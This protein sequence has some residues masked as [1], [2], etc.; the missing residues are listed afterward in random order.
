MYRLFIKQLISSYLVFDTSTY[1][2]L[3]VLNVFYTFNLRPASRGR[4]KYWHDSD[5]L[6]KNKPKFSALVLIWEVEHYM[7][8]KSNEERLVHSQQ[9]KRPAQRRSN[10]FTAGCGRYCPTDRRHQN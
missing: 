2:Q 6:K 4:K 10:F 7:S 9:E 8:Q 1:K 5:I 3:N